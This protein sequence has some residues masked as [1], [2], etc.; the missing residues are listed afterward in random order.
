MA[1]H[2]NR[3]IRS[4][5][6]TGLQ[7][8]HAVEQQALALIDRQLDRLVRYPEL[9]DR[10]RLHRAET[11][12]Q[13]A[14]LDEILRSLHESHSSFKDLAMNLIGNVAAIGNAMAGDEI[15]K[16]SFV[17]FAFENFEIAS[18]RSLLALAEA[19]GFAAAAPL[20]E[21]TLREE[22]AMAAWLEERL[23]SITLAY[24]GLRE[25]GR[26]ASH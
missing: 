9:A 7:N 5:F 25:Q 20:L 26:P 14:R 12:Q 18:Y 4:I 3:T 13:V 23:P 21:T 17:T 11:R 8:A 6:V 10:L 15:L 1:S 24:A 2:P 16:N 22:Q 19:G